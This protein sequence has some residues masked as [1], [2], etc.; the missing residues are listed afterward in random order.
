MVKTKETKEIKEKKITRRRRDTNF[1]WWRIFRRSQCTNNV[2]TLNTNHVHTR[3]TEI[4]K[5]TNKYQSNKE[6]NTYH[7]VRNSTITIR[8]QLLYTPCESENA[9]INNI[10]FPV[11][12][13][14]E[15]RKKQ[16]LS[17]HKQNLS[18]YAKKWEDRRKKKIVVSRFIVCASYI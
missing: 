3:N 14:I 1:F 4:N 8:K 2:G 12:L 7:T 10:F 18:K 5:Q 17:S 11:N 6:R 9:H 15:K 13:F 16:N